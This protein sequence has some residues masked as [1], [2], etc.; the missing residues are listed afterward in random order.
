MEDF[1]ELSLERTTKI[2]ASRFSDQAT[3]NIGL[4]N[5]DHWQN[6]D[7]WTGPRPIVDD[8]RYGV[9][10][11]A[12]KNAFVSRN[13][14]GEA[15]GRH[16]SGVLGRELH[17]RFTVE[18]PL[19][20]VEVIDPIT[21]ETVM[22]DGEPTDEEQALIGEAEAFMTAWWDKREVPEILQNMLDGALVAKRS[23]LRLH[24]PPGLR[25]KNGNLPTGTLDQ[26]LDYI[27]LQHLGTNE[28]TLDQ[29]VPSAT[30]YT[31]KN[32]RRDVGIFT[33]KEG[34]EEGEGQEEERAELSY[35]DE[36]GN[37]VLRIVGREVNVTKPFLMP[38]GGRLTIYEL[39]RKWLVTPQVVSQQK[40]LNKTLTMQGRNDDLGGFLERTYLGVEWPMEK[41]PVTGEETDTP[42]IMN[43]GAGAMNILQG[44]KWTDEKGNMH[45]T[46]PQV[47]Y[48]DPVSPQTFIDSAMATYLA[49]LSETQQLHYASASDAAVS[50]E[51]RKQAREAF[52][53]DLQHSGG[54]VESAARWVL[55]TTLAMA[56]FFAG[57]PNRFEGLRAYVQCRIDLGPLS[58]DDM[59]MSAEMYERGVWALETAQSATGIEDVDAENARIE[60]EQT[61]K[62]LRDTNMAKAALA[63]A[64]RRFD[65]EGMGADQ[66]AQPIE[67]AVTA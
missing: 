37:T 5:G 53:S 6:A 64:E 52:K 24:V 36:Q 21:G 18:R 26:C 46:T 20:A 1:S 59:R 30:V 61:K 38:L 31:D 17:W 7:M 35:V 3:V 56:S 40:S 23:P 15:V 22:E 54:K 39:T 55:E 41:D 4:L 50:G 44:E 63:E 10:M 49:I 42:K 13:V 16:T 27:W 25:D 66:E 32:T 11:E 29:Q 60:R 8:P 12:I 48:R 47:I 65:Q 43:V 19:E 62:N 58:A 57:Q 33:Y 34:G 2:V 28:D 67:G 9:K 14:I 45:V 51:S